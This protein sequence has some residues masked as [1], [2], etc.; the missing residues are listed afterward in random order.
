[1]K[2]IWVDSQK[3]LG[4]KTCELQCAVE[5]NSVTRKL[6]EA[7][8]EVPRPAPRVGVYG[9]SGHSFPLQCRH[10]QDA[11]CLKA[12]P[13]GAMQR[14]ADSD[15]T[16]I[17]QS[18]CRGCWMCVMSCPFGT[19]TPLRDFK[20]AQKCD[21]CMHME[22]PACVASCPTEALLYGEEDVFEK[23]RLTRKTMAALHAQAIAGNS[24]VGLDY[25]REDDES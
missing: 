14:E 19:V 1:M 12:C 3:C 24:V 5:R 8:R 9:P 7:V 2:R 16:Y 15:L 10:C 13:S 23:V 18:K 4:C 21:A 17:D 11:A 25:V 20:V 6:A 22:Q